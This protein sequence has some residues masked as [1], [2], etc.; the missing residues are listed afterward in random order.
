M[1]TLPF[2]LATASGRLMNLLFVL[3]FVLGPIA[4]KWGTQRQA[5]A[6]AFYRAHTTAQQRT[7]LDGLAKDAAAWAERFASSPA[8]EQKMKQ[9]IAF[10]QAALKTRGITLDVQEIIGAIQSAVAAAKVAGVLAAAGPTLAVQ[11]TPAPI[12]PPRPTPPA[13]APAPKPATV[14][15]APGGPSVNVPVTVAQA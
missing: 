2:S 4:Y 10:V 1:T 14:P 5:A 6:L 12:I 9:A 3:V 13:P 8:G 11:P 15:V 7:V